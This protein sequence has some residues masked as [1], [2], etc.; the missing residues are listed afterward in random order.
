[1]ELDLLA[2]AERTLL[3]RLCVFAG[4]FTLDDVEAVCCS[5]DLPAAH[6]LDHLSSLLDRSLVIKE[7][8]PG[9][10]C[11]RTHETMRE[12]ARLKLRE[13]GDEAAVEQRCAGH[14]LSRCRHFAVAGRHRLLEWRPWMELQIDN[15]RAVLRRSLDEDDPGRG[16]DL[17]TCLMRYW[18]TRGRLRACG[19]STSYSPRMPNVPPTPVPIS[20]VAS[21][22]CCKATRRPPCQHSTAV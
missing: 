22:P 8:I 19:G 2:P 11:C 15:V 18:I 16:I 17:A 6:A 20:S 9:A 13:G 3:T 21:S 1:V 5:D 7:D 4:D 10:A 12:Y 14:Y